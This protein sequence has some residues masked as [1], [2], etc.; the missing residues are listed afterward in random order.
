[1]SALDPAA[2]AC[3]LLGA[4]LALSAGA[5][6]VRF[7]HTLER[8]HA[9]TKP[10]VAGVLLVLLAMW[11]HRPTWGNAG[12]LAL[13]ATSQVIT[14]AVAAYMVARAAYARDCSREDEDDG[15]ALPP[16]DPP[17]DSS[18]DSSGSSG[19]S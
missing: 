1:M 8:M 12:P 11:L 19:S 2:G 3:L 6:L 15:T 5:G 13:V 14:V 17:E 9:G 7:R 18:D 4:G 10:Q 16:E